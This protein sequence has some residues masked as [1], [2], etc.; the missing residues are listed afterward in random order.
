MIKWLTNEYDEQRD[1]IAE[2]IASS[3]LITGTVSSGK[4]V[5]V[6]IK[7]VFANSLRLSHKCMTG[8]DTR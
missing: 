8:Y 1:N 6:R 3:R 5:N 4:P 2:C 7:L